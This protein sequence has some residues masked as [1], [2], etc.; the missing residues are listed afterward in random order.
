MSEQNKVNV[1]PVLDTDSLYRQL[2]EQKY[3]INVEI[4]AAGLNSQLQSAV[5]SV[6]GSMAPAKI[7]V[8]ADT[9]GLEKVLSFSNNLLGT[10]SYTKEL[11]KSV[12]ISLD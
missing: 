9:S 11:G 7:P 10:I 3:K 5:N 8:E 1:Q 2:N 12:N 4:D 6:A